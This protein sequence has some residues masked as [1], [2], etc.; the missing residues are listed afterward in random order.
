M[1]QDEAIKVLELLGVESPGQFEALKM[2]IEALKVESVWIV[3]EVYQG[4]VNEVKAF[5]TQELAEAVATTSFQ[6]HLTTYGSYHEE[7]EKRS[8]GSCS[9]DEYD[10]LVFESPVQ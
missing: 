1:R 9:C 7:A 3:I 2:G 10:I 6:E 4:V 8:Y 5:K